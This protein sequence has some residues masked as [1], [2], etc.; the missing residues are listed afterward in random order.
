[1]KKKIGELEKELVTYTAK[2]GSYAIALN[3]KK[4]ENAEL[5]VNRIAFENEVKEYKFVCDE[6]RE[7]VIRLEE[8]CKIASEREKRGVERVSSL[9]NEVEKVNRER[10]KEVVELKRVIRE[11]ECDK[12]RVEEESDNVMKRVKEME[13]RVRELECD[14]RRAEKESEEYKKRVKEMKTRA[15]KEIEGY[16]K[17]EKVTETR[18]AKLEKEVVDL[19]CLA[20]DFEVGADLSYKEEKEGETGNCKTNGEVNGS[21]SS[22]LNIK[23]K[24]LSCSGGVRESV[25]TGY[26]SHS[27]VKGSG[28]GQVE[29][30]PVFNLLSKPLANLKEE[31]VSEMAHG[32]GGIKNTVIQLTGTSDEKRG[33]PKL[34]I[35]R[36]RFET[37]I[38]ISDSDNDMETVPEKSLSNNSVKR[39]CSN[40]MFEENGSSSGEKYSQV[41]PLKRKRRLKLVSSDSEDDDQIPIAK[42]QKHREE[43]SGVEHHSD[44]SGKQS[45]WAPTVSYQGENI[46]QSLYP[47]SHPSI[48]LRHCEEKRRTDECVP[49]RPFEMSGTAYNKSESITQNRKE[50]GV[51]DAVSDRECKKFNEFCVNGP[52]EWEREGNS[53]NPNKAGD[54]YTLFNSRIKANRNW[55]NWESAIDMDTSFEAEPKLCMRAVC[56]LYQQHKRQEKRMGQSLHFTSRGFSK[57]DERRYGLES[58]FSFLIQNSIE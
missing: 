42:L 56:A 41:S 30:P 23:E 10:V 51:E 13:I 45:C 21:G 32:S 1:M 53:I 16:K 40:Q 48:S 26:I 31:S 3:M 8:D 46:D 17:R 44:S 24:G 34:G 58:S 49:L 7:K 18:V 2:C 50:K 9:S 11:L 25:D 19:V 54:V 36:P 43:G 27:P 29:G 28:A 5:E 39:A 47:S 37:V 12:R 33:S 38:E 57:S 6:L 4:K 14:K 20:P 55:R 15:W 22:E 52:N 35:E